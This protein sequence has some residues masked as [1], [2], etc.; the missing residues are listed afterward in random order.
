MPVDGAGGHHAY[1]LNVFTGRPAISDKA[2]GQEDTSNSQDM[3]YGQAGS[4]ALVAL[5][6]KGDRIS[7][8][9]TGRLAVGV[10]RS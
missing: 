6:R 9:Y 2:R 10:E 1:L 7:S 5:K 4:R 8:G 3:I